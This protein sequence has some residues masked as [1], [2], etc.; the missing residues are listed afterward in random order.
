MN[1]LLCRSQALYIYKNTRE[2]N[3]Q[4]PNSETTVQM[5]HRCRIFCSF[6][7]MANSLSWRLLPW[8][9]PG[10]LAERQTI[11][12]PFDT[13]CRF[14][15]FPHQQVTR[16]K[17]KSTTR[18]KLIDQVATWKQP[19]QQLQAVIIKQQSIVSITQYL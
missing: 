14:A 4:S 9:D 17:G 7:A 8:K 16:N 15:V 18:R 12:F 2:N 6:Q 10:T 19:A 11:F 1:T 13:C 3:S 5:H